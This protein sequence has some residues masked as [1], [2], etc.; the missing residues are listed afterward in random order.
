ML[1][2]VLAILTFTA[3]S[4]FPRGKNCKCKKSKDNFD[5]LD[6][7]GDERKTVSVDRS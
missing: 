3:N 2:W 1:K 5:S 6:D 4:P 7:E